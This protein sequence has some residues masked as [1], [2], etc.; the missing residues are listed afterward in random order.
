MKEKLLKILDIHNH[1]SQVEPPSKIL[2]MCAEKW[3]IF[4]TQQ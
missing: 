3:S 2:E 4:K 1:Y